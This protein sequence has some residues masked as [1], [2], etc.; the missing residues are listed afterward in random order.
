[1]LDLILISSLNDFKN[2]IHHSLKIAVNTR[3][4]LKDKLEGIGLYTLEVVKRMAAA[5]PE[6]EF[7]FFF[8]R[9]F[10]PSFVFSKNITPVVLS[11]PARHP[12]LFIAWF[13]WSVARALRQHK[14]DVFLS[15]DNFLSLSTDTPTVLIVH[16]IA[17]THFSENDK[18]VNRQYY[19]FF[20]PRFLKR[21]NAILAVSEFTKQDILSKFSFVEKNKITVA[22][23]GCR[24][25]FKPLNFSQKKEKNA[26]NTEGPLFFLFVGAVHPRKN[27]HRLIQAFDLFKKKV[28]SNVQ[29]VL[30]GRFAWQTGAVKSAYD[31]ATFKQDIIFKGYVEDEEVV[32]L[33]A[34]AL[35]VTYVSLF[36]G[37]GVP[38]LEAMNCDTPIITSNVSSMPEV[39]G[40][41]AILV[42]PESIEAIADAMQAVFDNDN[43]REKLIEHG[44]IQR[45]KF[46]WNKT[47]DIVYYQLKNICK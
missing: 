15:P 17:F 27:V 37:F 18:W 43:L 25:V 20:T 11:P 10:D 7:I 45:A 41:A 28:K 24:E 35:A 39:V 16:D 32:K 4:L 46:D 14:V 1:L 31:A 36:E 12:L 40:E 21:A 13:E 23:N 34:S 30:C 47:A 19:K 6:D 9:P 44:R 26:Q 5:H 22:Y 29:L 33:T 3:F 2:P 42:N 38:L 8:D